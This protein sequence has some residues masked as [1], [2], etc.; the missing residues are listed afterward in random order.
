MAMIGPFAGEHRFLSNFAE[1]PVE[2]EGDTYP[3]V[4]HAFQAA[5]TYDP[6]ERA[7][8]RAA[9]SPVTAKRLGK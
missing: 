1:V 5:K 4:E 8:V 9:S 7:R 2:Y 6:E 3:T